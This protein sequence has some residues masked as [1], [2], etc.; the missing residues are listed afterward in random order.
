[1]YSLQGV[2]DSY[3][4]NR[5]KYSQPQAL[6]F[7]NYIT[8]DSNNMWI[9]ACQYLTG[10]SPCLPTENTDFIVLSDHGRQA[11]EFSSERIEN[12]VRTINGTMRSYWIA[13]KYSLSTSWTELPSRSSIA[14]PLEV[15]DQGFVQELQRC[16]G[17]VDGGAGGQDLIK[18]YEDH[19]G[20]FWV[21]MAYDEHK[22]PTI[23]IN[24]TTIYDM[25]F[26]YPE[27]K[28][29]YFADFSHTVDK[30]QSLYTTV[31]GNSY[32][33]DYD[34]WTVNIALEEV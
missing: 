20:P 7:A 24:G 15:N 8:K 16:L 23:D 11:L 6:L 27:A 34:V 14:G 25:D 29:F 4:R 32:K 26:G 3:V 13:D 1:M 19:K 5:A 21:L 9:P 33:I 18:W 30:R 31:D 22:P 10:D 2:N 17:T 28:Q 12:R